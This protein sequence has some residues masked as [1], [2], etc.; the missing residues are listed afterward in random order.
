[1]Q[2]SSFRGV[3]S[4]CAFSDERSIDIRGYPKAKAIHQP[5]NIRGG[6]AA[7]AAAL[8]IILPAPSSATL[9][10]IVLRKSGCF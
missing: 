8:L 3:G 6:A 5:Q 10:D 7:A 9:N 4:E 2:L 1:M